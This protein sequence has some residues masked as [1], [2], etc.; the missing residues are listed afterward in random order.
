M[1]SGIPSSLSNAPIPKRPNE[2]LCPQPP[3]KQKVERELIERFMDRS[4]PVT[5]VQFLDVEDI[6]QLS[7]ICRSFREVMGQIGRPEEFW[8]YLF[9][10]E[11]IPRVEQL[12]DQ[13]RDLKEDFI[14]LYQKTAVSGKRI[15]RFLGNVVGK[16]PEITEEV[17]ERSKGEPHMGFYVRPDAVQRT[18]GPDFP[19]QLVK[20]RVLSPDPQKPVRYESLLYPNR[21]LM[22]EGEVLTIPLGIF[23]LRAL[24]DYPRSGREH[25][26]CLKVDKGDERF[27]TE[28]YLDGLAEGHCWNPYHLFNRASDHVKVDYMLKWGVLE[29]SRW[30]DDYEERHYLG[31]DENVEGAFVGLREHQQLLEQQGFKLAGA[32]PIALREVIK[33]LEMGVGS[34]ADF[35]NEF[36]FHNRKLRSDCGIWNF[37][38]RQLPNGEWQPNDRFL[39]VEPLLSDFPPGTEREHGLIDALYYRTHGHAIKTRAH[40]YESIQVRMGKFAGFTENWDGGLVIGPDRQGKGLSIDTDVQ[41]FYWGDVGVVPRL[42]AEVRAPFES[43]E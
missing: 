3:K 4:T 43:A 9:K 22:G 35:S 19:M 6:F 13:K 17:F 34:L 39:D 8:A 30:V 11:G 5:I 40:T 25:A 20:M 36:Y 38:Q 24:S 41:A 42:R 1:T 29:E 23:N 2:E 16:I 21:D 37:P 7:R 27:F 31:N 32:L 28:E 15:G 14:H 18:I 12:G 26:P 10:R 33:K